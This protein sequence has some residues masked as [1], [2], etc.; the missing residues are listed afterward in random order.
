ME[1]KAYSLDNYSY[2]GTYLPEF[3]KTNPEFYDF[4]CP[5]HYTEDMSRLNV[6]YRR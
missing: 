3:R 6:M 4:H 1:G 2:P 5:K